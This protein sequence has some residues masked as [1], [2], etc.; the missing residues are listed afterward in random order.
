[1]NDCVTLG[2]GVAWFPAFRS[3]FSTFPFLWLFT[4]ISGHVLPFQGFAITN[5]VLLWTSDQLD[6]DTFLS[7]NTQHS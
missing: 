4:L 1:V 7:C 5:I 2:G 3:A 6:A